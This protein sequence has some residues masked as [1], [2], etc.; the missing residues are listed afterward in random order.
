MDLRY[1]H[2]H[3]QSSTP[4][5]IVKRGKRLKL[6]SKDDC[7]NKMWYISAK[8]Y[9]AFKREDILLH[10]TIWMNLE[11]IVLSEISQSQKDKYYMI[12]LRWGLKSNS[13]TQKAEAG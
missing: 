13:Q 10:A 7:I 9:L 11:D 6:S 12:S 1:L 5:T 8:D 3:V 4:F 2:I